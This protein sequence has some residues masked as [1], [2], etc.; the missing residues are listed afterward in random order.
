MWSAAAKDDLESLPRPD[1]V[2]STH[3]PGPYPLRLLILGTGI[4]VGYGVL[5]HDLALAGH[6]AR[7]LSASIG[8]GV[9]IDVSVGTQLT[10][11]SCRQNLHEFGI[12][13]YDAVVVTLGMWDCVTLA[14]A[15]QWGRE[16]DQLLDDM[17]ALTPVG[18]EIFVVTMPASPISRTA[19]GAPRW[20]IDHHAE[21]LN[22]EMLRTCSTRPFATLV[23]LAESDPRELELSSAVATY[24]VLASKLVPP[25]SFTL[26]APTRPRLLSLDR[27]DEEHRQEALDR[28]NIVDTEPED[29]Y[30]RIV[31]LAQR[32]FGTEAAVVSLIDRNRQWFK[33]KRGTD[34][35]ETSRADAFCNVTIS[36]NGPLVVENAAQDFRFENNPLVT[37]GPKIRFYAGFPL[38]AP[39][40]E[41]VGT[42]C[43]FDSN[44]REFSADDHAALRSIAMLAQDELWVGP[45]EH[46]FA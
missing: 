7:Q 9:D 18:Q 44:P 10:P 24:S 33:A 23:D 45:R 6:L 3:V 22:A 5:R 37:G 34:L 46:S 11:S 30:E 43:I 39:N 21:V 26:G 38:E 14:A 16:Y 28:L 2:A 25:I 1:G 42:L 20:V 41:K 40:G 35:V 31:D 8:R 13:R 29:R 4:S 17:H 36:L 19:S 12:T 27:V 15:P 32:I